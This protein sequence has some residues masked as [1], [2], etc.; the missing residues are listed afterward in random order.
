[1]STVTVNKSHS[2]FNV[3]SNA[4]YIV[5]GDDDTI[6]VGSDSTLTANGSAL[7][8]QVTGAGS[9]VTIGGNGVGASN[10]NDNVVLFKGVTGTL[11]ELANARVDVTANLVVLTMAGNDALGVYGSGDSVTASG[12]GD[13][14]WIGQNG[15]D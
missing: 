8:V 9:V 4:G 12:A 11:H 5:N 10:T 6:L 15:F 1:M 7:S 14:L 3:G 2:T 13:A